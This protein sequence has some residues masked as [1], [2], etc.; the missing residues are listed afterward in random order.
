MPS[1]PPTITFL[2]LHLPPATSTLPAALLSSLIHYRPFFLS[3][4]LLPL[5]T[6]G[7]TL[8]SS[9][10]AS[11]ATVVVS[12][13][14]LLLPHRAIE[15]YNQPLHPLPSASAPPLHSHASRRHRHP[16]FLSSPLLVAPQPSPLQTPL[17]VTPVA[18][19]AAV[20]ASPASL[21]LSRAFLRYLLPSLPAP[22]SIPTSP[23]LKRPLQTVA[24]ISSSLPL[25]LLQTAASI[26]SIAATLP[27]AATV[28]SH[29]YHP[30]LLPPLPSPLLQ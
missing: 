7:P 2:F 22:S 6:V 17:L 25:L 28:A 5:P 16:F 19:V 8:L 3:S 26:S 24:V 13:Q 12:T 21:A 1:S 27:L 11:L 23:P 30:P 9:S 29:R 4:P 14:L 15:G 20:V 10:S 18:P